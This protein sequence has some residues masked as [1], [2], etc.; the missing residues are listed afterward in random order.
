M[1]AIEMINDGTP[2][3]AIGG[4]VERIIKGSGFRPIVDLNGH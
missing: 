4:A 1:I 2:V 3:N